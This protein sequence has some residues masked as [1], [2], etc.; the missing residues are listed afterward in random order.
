MIHDFSNLAP[1]EEPVKYQGQDYVLVEASAGAAI[2][3]RNARTNSLKFQDGKLVGYNNP[4][5]IE[6]LLVSLCVFAIDKA[7]KRKPVSVETIKSWP[8]QMV[9]TLF[10]RA[11]EIGHLQEQFAERKAL[12]KALSQ[13]GSPA[14]VEDLREYVL[15]LCDKPDCPLNVVERNQVLSLLREEEEATSKN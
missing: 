9:T 15:S 11:K 4:A 2:T 1:I 14:S 6:P 10:E 5:E 13:E 8:S 7:G 3:F 12:A